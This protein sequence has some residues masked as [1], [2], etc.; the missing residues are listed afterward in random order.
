MGWNMGNRPEDVQ[1]RADEKLRDYERRMVEA[2]LER[3]AERANGAREGLAGRLAR[4]LFRRTA[5]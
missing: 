1:A 2:R 3:E 4:R 5:R